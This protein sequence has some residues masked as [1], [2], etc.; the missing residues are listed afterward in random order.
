MERATLAE[1]EGRGADRIGAPTAA[2]EAIVAAVAHLIASKGVRGLRVEE[3]AAQAKVSPPLLYYHFKNRSGLI[4]AALERASLNAAVDPATSNGDGGTGYERVEC[5]LLCEFADDDA[6]RDNAAVWNE[7]NASAVFDI[8]LRA[9]LE[10]AN[11]AW[12]GALE[13]NILAGIA[14]RSVR[15]EIEPKAVAE[16]LASLVDGLCGR[17]LAGSLTPDEAR[18]LVK[19]TLAAA[20][21]PTRAG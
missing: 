19:I 15:D 18:R 6:V 7:V 8:A 16:I 5:S 14:D 9:D 3:V 10:H 21:A 1:G 17:W 4:R 20:L 13:E 12:R 11:A 2:R